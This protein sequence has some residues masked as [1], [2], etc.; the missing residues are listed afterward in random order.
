MVR[1]AVPARLGAAALGFV[2][3]T[4]G[5]ALAAPCPCS[6][7]EVYVDCAAKAKGTGKKDAPYESLAPVNVLKLKAGDKVHIRRG[8]TCKG[9]LTVRGAGEADRPITVD[10]Y[11]TGAAPVIEAT[12]AEQ[13]LLLDNAQQV[14]VSGLALTAPGDGG[15][16]RR[17]VL[18]RASDAGVLRGIV[19]TG[20]DIHD[21]RG[22]PRTGEGAAAG[23]SGGIVVEAGGDATPTT[24]DG[25]EITGN[26]IHTIG[27]AGVS[28]WSNWCRRPGSP[29]PGGCAQA[30]TPIRRLAVRGNLLWDVGGDG[31]T[32]AA[33]QGA[34]VDGNRLE[35]FNLRSDVFGAGISVTG[36]TTP[37]LAGNEVS[38]GATGKA[39]AGGMAFSLGKGT[40]GAV[41]SAGFSHDNAGGFAR[42]CGARAFTVR[43]NV[44]VNDRARAFQACDAPLEKGRIHGNTVYLADGVDQLIVDAEGSAELDVAFTGNLVE[45]TGT[46]GTVGWN[47]ESPAW[48]I[49]HNLLH[50]LPVPA[51]ATATVKADPALLAGGVA[52]PVAL[53]LK[54]GSPALGA[55][56][57]TEGMT[58]HPVSPSRVPAATPNIGG[59]QAAGAFP[60]A[61][62]DTFDAAGTGAPPAGWK[63]T[64]TAVTRPDPAGA[65][66]A[67]LSLGLAATGTA[68]VRP[69]PVTGG[70][71]R[72]RA[73]L[74]A[75]A[76]GAPVNLKVQDGA[77]AALASAGFDEAGRVRYTDGPDVR[78]VEGVSVPPGMWVPVSLLLRP[79]RGDYELWVNG[80]RHA[81]GEL[82]EG[83]GLAGRVAVEVPGGP[84]Q[85]TFWAD[86]V[87][88]TPEMCVEPPPAKAGAHRH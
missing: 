79:E 2:V 50:G 23:A 78:T 30:W 46:K 43:D 1:Y 45:R 71:L 24:F 19:L 87:L 13:A 26:R 42:L 75:E 59:I 48:V 33:T 55:G 44:S 40:D 18:V 80:R 4:P 11:G 14:T 86:D 57:R 73:R 58:G 68:A 61:L 88:V 16:P 85:A 64:G 31:V 15:Q 6:K 5:A 41:V 56:V 32:L 65:F 67:A 7:I 60:A 82:A 21:V 77:G 52:D 83:A 84:G 69:F 70:G 12:G 66:G 47:L 25:L 35:G 8:A 36:S 37:A 22:M 62:A 20:L 17:G 72:V 29:V 39:A 81:T 63:V 76:L 3:A 10:A 38:G 53:Q 74:R 51:T 28:T 27:G 34:K 54:A 49:D 9:T